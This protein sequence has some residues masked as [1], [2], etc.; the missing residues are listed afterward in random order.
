MIGARPSNRTSFAVE[1]D[2]GHRR[3]VDRGVVLTLD[4][5]AER[6]SD[7][8]RLEQPRRQL[9]EQ[10]L[11]RVVVVPVH[12]DDVDVGVLQLPCGT[13]PGE[14]AAENDDPRPLA[15]GDVRHDLPQTE[16][17]LGAALYGTERGTTAE[18]QSAILTISNSE[19]MNPPPGDHLRPRPGYSFRTGSPTEHRVT[20]W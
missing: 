12:D 17:R 16:L 14:A 4:E 2:R 3:L 7:G 1:V 8:R 6:V 18:L 13:D 19:T 5:I 15:A 9:V 11:E 10:R 20:F